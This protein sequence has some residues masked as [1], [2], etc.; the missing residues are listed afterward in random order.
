VQST[1]ASYAATC[2]LQSVV[3]EQQ[4][5]VS[6]LETELKAKDSAHG[7][8]QTKLEELQVLQPYWHHACTV[9]LPHTNCSALMPCVKSSN[10]KEE[11]AICLA[12]RFGS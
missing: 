3:K 12:Q 1:C 11:H 6:A 10:C 2:L 5:R 4:R 9:L 8:L 7:T